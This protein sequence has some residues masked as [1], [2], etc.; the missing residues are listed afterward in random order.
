MW[1][2]FAVIV[3]GVLAIDLFV[4]HRDPHAVRVREAL[5][6]S[7]V[8]IT[9]SLCFGLAL[10]LMGD[11]GFGTERSLQFLG[12]YVIELALSVDNLFV[13]A[14][15]FAA[16]RIPREFQHKLLFWGVFGALVLR[17]V[18]VF[19]GVA[20]IAAFEP[21]LYVFGAIL[22]IT[23]I[24]MLFHA[25]KD[26]HP[27]NGLI[28]RTLS[29]VLPLKPANVGPTF[30][31]REEGKLYFTMLF[32]GL[33]L[34]EITDVI[35]AVDSVP[36]VLSIAMDP[37]TKQA[38]PF[39]V[40]TSNA[41]AILGLRSLYFALA[42]IM[43]A[44]RFLKYGLSVI[45]IFVGVKMMATLGLPEFTIPGVDWTIYVPPFHM[46]IAASLGVIGGVLA[47]CIA[48]SLAIPRRP[49]EPA[50]GEAGTK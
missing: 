24:R 21:V 14:I 23:A 49:A 31:V 8:W 15:I 35:F 38:D 12:G 16:L 9:L 26:R 11:Y 40:Y 33:V 20:L 5:I 50:S 13:F 17:G 34:V 39:I 32:V 7:G 18:F 29:R 44:F 47:V 27:E 48:L 6:W 22:V 43:A 42:G 41:F 28:V 2:V 25:D 4:L 45:L 46:P 3:L 10:A 19:A 37:V 36:A 1:G 30:T